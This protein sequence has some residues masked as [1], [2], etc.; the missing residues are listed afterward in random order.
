[1]MFTNG[2]I[3][4]FSSNLIPID[5]SLIETRTI[6]STDIMTNEYI[7]MISTEPIPITRKYYICLF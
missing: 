7:T 4:T 1:M 5:S 6:I 2:E 3:T